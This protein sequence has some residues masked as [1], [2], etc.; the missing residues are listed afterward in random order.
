MSL[1]A[2]HICFIVLASSLSLAFGVWAFLNVEQGGSRIAV[3]LGSV[4]VGVSLL[5]YGSWFLRKM[6]DVRVP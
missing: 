3:S 2:F 4:T 1:K 5:G 6:R